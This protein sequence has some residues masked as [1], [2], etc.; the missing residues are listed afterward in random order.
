MKESNTL[1]SN[2]TIKQ[3]QKGILLD[4]KGQYMK[5]SN[6]RVGNVTIKHP[7]RQILPN[8]KGQYMKKSRV[9]F[10]IDV[11]LLGDFFAHLQILSFEKL[12]IFLQNSSGCSVQRSLAPSNQLTVPSPTSH[13]S[14]IML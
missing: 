6:I 8:T 9:K 12:D 1:A 11:R 4:T 7:P 5:E 13:T 2:A 14:C 3:L 10:K